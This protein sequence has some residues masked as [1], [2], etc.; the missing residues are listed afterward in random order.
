VLSSF[1]CRNERSRS[2][3]CGEFLTSTAKIVM[4]CNVKVKMK[5]NFILLQAMKACRGI[6]GITPLILNLDSTWM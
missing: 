3:K 2:T 4:S 5:V 6:E 1:K